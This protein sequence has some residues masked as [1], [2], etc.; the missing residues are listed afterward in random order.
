MSHG[1]IESF[2]IIEEDV[3]TQTS[4]FVANSVSDIRALSVSSVLNTLITKSLI[5]MNYEMVYWM[6]KLQIKFTV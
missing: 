2:G 4:Q 3:I 5:V 6:I 1:S